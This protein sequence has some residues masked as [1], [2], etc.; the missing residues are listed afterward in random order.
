M[1]APGN[2]NA[3]SR[4]SGADNAVCCDAATKSVIIVGYP[5]SCA[6]HR[7]CLV[8]ATPMPEPRSPGWVAAFARSMLSGGT[9]RSPAGQR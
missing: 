4:A 1:S 5:F 6:Q 2:G 3:L 9:R 7:T 8:I